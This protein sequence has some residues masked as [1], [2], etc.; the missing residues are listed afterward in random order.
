MEPLGHLAR[1]VLIETA[2]DVDL[3]ELLEL[4][5]RVGE[6]LADLAVDV[7]ALRVALAAHGYVL[8]HSH[9]HRAGNEAGQTGNGDRT[10]ASVRRGDADHD[11]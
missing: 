7:G 11:R 4:Q 10:A 5:L 1:E 6:L 9:R 3:R 8:A 2:P